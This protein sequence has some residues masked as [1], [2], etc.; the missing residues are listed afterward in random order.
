VIAHTFGWQENLG[1]KAQN[2]AWFLRL[3]DIS[4]ETANRLYA[5][6]WGFSLTGAVVTLLGV[7]MLWWGTRVRD[8]DFEHNIAELHV[9]AAKS[10]LEVA[11]LT[12]PRVRLLTPEAVAAFVE[13]L[14]RSP[15]QN[16]T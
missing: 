8:K 10:E 1:S 16:L 4:L 9:R 13:R 15:G 14:R 11:R 7:G 12:T 6:G 5:L 3:I 2:M